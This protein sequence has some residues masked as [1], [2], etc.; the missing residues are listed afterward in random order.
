MGLHRRLLFQ[1]VAFGAIATAVAI[2]LFGIYVAHTQR[3]LEI[4]ALESE[5]QLIAD[6]VGNDVTQYLIAQDYRNL[7]HLLQQAGNNPG[8]MLLQV[9][10]VD[11]R[12]VS[13]MERSVAGSAVRTSTSGGRLP[14]PSNMAG[15]IAAGHDRVEVWRPIRGNQL[16]GWVHVEHDLEES[17]LLQSHLLDD[18]MVIGL[19][20]L[21]LS[22]VLMFFLVRKPIGLI[23]QATAFAVRLPE[24]SGETMGEVAASGEIGNLIHAL[25]TASGQLHDQGVALAL[26]HA[27]EERRRRIYE[28]MAM[29]ETPVKIMTMI[30]ASLEQD[31]PGALVAIMVK[32]KGGKRLIHGAAPSL[33]QS[34]IDRLNGVSVVPGATSCGG[35]A[36]TGQR[37]ITEH[38]PSHADWDGYQDAAAQAGL[39]ACWAEPIVD[40][41]DR[42]LGVLAVYLRDRC[43]PS[44]AQQELLHQVANLLTVVLR[45]VRN[46]EALLLASS[47]FQA[48]G[49]AITVTDENNCIIAIN[50]AFTRVTGYS[51]EE[52]LGKNPSMLSSGRMDSTFYRTMWRSLKETGQWQ[53]EIWN[54]RKSGQVFAEWLTINAIHDDQGRAYRHVA[55]FSDI[56][57]KKRAEE[58]IWQQA[59]YDQLTELPNRRLFRDRLEQE[60][61][62]A[63]RNGNLLALLFIDLDRFKTVNDTMGHDAGDE[64]LVQAANRLKDCVR[65]SD[66]VARL[67]SDEFAMILTEAND[68]GGVERKAQHIL[69]QLAWP[70]TLRAGMAY[71]SASIG[72]TLFPSDGGE[73]ESLLLNAARAMSAAKNGGANAFSWYTLEMQMAARVRSELGHDLRVA[74][75]ENQFQVHYQPIV[76]LHSG[77]VVK[78][79]ALIR[80]PHPE[81][82]WVSPVTFIPLAEELGMIGEVG[83]W[84]F[85]TVARQA[86]DW[87]DCGLDLQY[88]VNKSP[89]QFGAADNQEA[90]LD[91]LQE[92]ELPARHLVIEITEGLLLDARV[93][94]MQ[95]LHQLRE[96]GLQVAIDDFGTGYSALSYLQQFDI[97]Y[98]KIDRSFIKDLEEG[99]DGAALA[100]AI[101]VMAHKL[102]I[103]VIAEGVETAF[104]RDWLVDAQCDYVQGFFYAKALPAEEFERL[105]RSG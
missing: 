1:L 17:R 32:D 26:A 73:A 45:R 27:Q 99:A 84:V 25:N 101:V 7:D 30:A 4:R 80:W 49:E 72:I 29:G 53:G 59:N 78:A 14:I 42:V 82:G 61:R 39:A 81:R 13:Q 103:Q 41:P 89:R 23:R 75:Q 38:I 47:V 11:G 51:V 46:E 87:L 60:L 95:Q 69:T 34:F 66:T 33:P 68:P 10:T 104:Q 9:V 96:A 3:A 67:G 20:V 97:D 5:V 16:L 44:A 91:Y 94:V 70:Y 63:E 54:K 98:L 74:L 102:G 2:L 50:P 62:R 36:S 21:P 93:E 40:G 6:D 57:E 100:E 76:D 37:S 58:T 28:A 56:S 22:A 71:L 52:V 86:K 15:G 48:S 19:L 79:E 35:A 85:R 77:R 105:V 83:D 24:A 65:D 64:L 55:I 18:S 92:I 88:S 90:W 31:I 8:V 43:R 12:I